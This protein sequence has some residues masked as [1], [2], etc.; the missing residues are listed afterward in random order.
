MKP[1][2]IKLEAGKFKTIK[3]KLVSNKWTSLVSF[4][5]LNMNR[6]KSFEII[7]YTLFTH[8]GFL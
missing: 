6:I 3:M 1:Y 2:T 7:L 8:K 5:I 4:Q